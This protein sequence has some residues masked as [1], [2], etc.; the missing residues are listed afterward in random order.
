MHFISCPLFSQ[1]YAALFFSALVYLD[2]HMN[3]PPI[4]F[5]LLLWKR[6]VRFHYLVF[7]LLYMLVVRPCVWQLLGTFS[8]CRKLL[9]WNRLPA[10]KYSTAA[11]RPWWL[12]KMI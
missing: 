12:K 8:S 5:A 3:I 2:T 6:F 9:E 4:L 1:P 10:K 11:G 7:D